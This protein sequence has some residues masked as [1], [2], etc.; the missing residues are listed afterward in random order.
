MSNKNDNKSLFIYTALIFS[1]AV[2]LILLSFFGQT[3]MQKNQ[4]QIEEKQEEKTHTPFG[5]AQ[6]AS[7][8]SEEN[9][10]LLTENSTL[11]K[12]IETLTADNDKLKAANESLEKSK[13]INDLLLSA[14]GYY[15][16]NNTTKS[17]E[18]IESI[19]YDELTS[20]QKIIYDNLKSNLQ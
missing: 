19:S 16:M 5:I 2:V 13:K 6:K 15:S 4:P 12:E 10:V 14:N 11:K 8:L 7:V 3:N 17:K 18:I 9:T 20:D 1:V